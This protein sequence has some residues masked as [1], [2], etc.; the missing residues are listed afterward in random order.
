MEDSEPL[1]V[2]T[3]I[4][5]SS[6]AAA[7]IRSVTVYQALQAERLP[8]DEHFTLDGANLDKVLLV[9]HVML[10]PGPNVRGTYDLEDGTGRIYGIR[11][12]N[13]GPVGQDP[14]TFSAMVQQC[15][16]GLAC[17]IGR[18]TTLR[19]GQNMLNIE[20]MS[21]VG[22][23]QAMFHILECM[24]TSLI[25]IKGSPAR[26]EGSETVVA[27]E[28]E[29]DSGA[30]D[31]SYSNHSFLD[32]PQNDQ[33]GGVGFPQT[34]A[35]LLHGD[36]SESSS[37]V[38]TLTQAAPELP[39][40]PP[41]LEPE[42][43]HSAVRVAHPHAVA[44]TPSPLSSFGYSLRIS[45]H[46]VPQYYG[47]LA[48]LT[49]TQDAIVSSLSQLQDNTLYGAWIADVFENVTRVIAITWEEFR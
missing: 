10:R 28:L 12:N 38:L 34:A 18:L 17:V 45:S 13:V 2:E 49:A 22:Y 33:G 43:T 36:H 25:I 15:D 27:Q 11:N 37:S 46:P 14:A 20:S 5:K 6:E 35:P 7:S 16:N 26:N 44:R 32:L 39:T 9:T 30:F 21:V 4:I 42:T 41:A 31:Q 8:G 48:Q 23:H 29:G 47:Q 1:L 19:N 40:R 3:T 24:T